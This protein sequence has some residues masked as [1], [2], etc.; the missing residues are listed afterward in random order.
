MMREVLLAAFIMGVGLC[1]AGASTHLYQW[2]ARQQAMLRYD[3]KTFLS[4]MGNVVLSF[5]CGPYIML[6][7][8][9]TQEDQGTLAVGPA[10]VS[11]L[12]AFGW[13]FITGLLFM[14]VYV[15]IRYDFLLR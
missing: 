10:L 9:W 12:V 14:G 15:A 8:G 1:V 7:L 6:Q 2:V 3:G 11:A 4:S 13:A 5:I